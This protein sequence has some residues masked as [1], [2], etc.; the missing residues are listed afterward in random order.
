MEIWT[1]E[2]ITTNENIIRD[3][4]QDDAKMDMLNMW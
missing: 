3:E 1:E 2:I 4:H